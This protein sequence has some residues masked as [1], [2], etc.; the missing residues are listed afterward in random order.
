MGQ[1]H[2]CIQGWVLQNTDG[3]KNG[4]KPTKNKDYKGVWVITQS[5]TDIQ[6]E[7]ESIAKI[8]LKNI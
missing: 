2:Q 3:P 1:G 5:G 6:L 4:W 7:L 8:I